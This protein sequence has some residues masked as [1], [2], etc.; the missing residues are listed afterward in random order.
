VPIN[1]EGMMSG[2]DWYLIAVVGAFSAFA[3]TLFAVSQLTRR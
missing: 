1:L 3:V 2:E